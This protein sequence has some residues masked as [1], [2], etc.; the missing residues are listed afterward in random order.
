VKRLH[1]EDLHYLHYQPDAIWVRKSRRVRWECHVAHVEERR[2]ADKFLAKIL[3]GDKPLGR[4]VFRWE[5]DIVSGL[6]EGGFVKL[7]TGSSHGL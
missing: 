3:E 7:K 4:S 6:K 2:N 1:S 5:D